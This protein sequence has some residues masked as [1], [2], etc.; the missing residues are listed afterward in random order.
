MA[1][2]WVNVRVRSWLYEQMRVA[3]ENEDR[4]VSSWLDMILERFFVGADARAAA[5]MDMLAVLRQYDDDR[6]AV[7]R[8]QHEKAEKMMK[9]LRKQEKRLQAMLDGAGPARQDAP[10]DTTDLT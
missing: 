1:T 5:T 10:P 6:D 8:M 4:S 2:R 9:R 7:L 3:A